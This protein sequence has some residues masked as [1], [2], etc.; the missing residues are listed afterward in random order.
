MTGTIIASQNP[1]AISNALGT[2]NFRVENT[3]DENVD[4]EYFK[5][6]F[7][8]LSELIEAG[9]DLVEEVEGEGAVL[10]KNDNN[11]LP[12]A[13]GSKI[14]LFSVSSVKPAYGGRGSA[15][16]SFPQPP[17][18]PKEGFENAGFS[19]NES[20]NNFYLTNQGKYV[21]EGRGDQALV[22]D[23]PWTDIVA[24]NLDTSIREYSDAAFFIV[25]RVGGEGSDLASKGVA[26]GTDGDHLKLSVNE[27]SVLKGLKELK[28]AGT[29]KKIIVLLNTSNQIQSSYL[30]DPELGV[31]AA[32]WIGSVGVTGF[33]AVGKL[34]SGDITPSGHL[35]DAHWYNH[36]DNPVSKNFGAYTYAGVNDY[37]LPIVAGKLILSI[38]HTMYIKKVYILDIDML[39]QD[40]QTLLQIEQMLEHLLIRMLFH[41][42]LVMVHHIQNLNSLISKQQN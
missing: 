11:A 38:L 31:D 15:Q 1:T 9:R 34:V 32:L 2:P 6:K 18:T 42:H 26:D 33:N 24:A 40:M 5:S 39:K 16:T 35:S 36:K 4:S 41:I 17:V 14:S 13:K 29:I 10:L 7:S 25:T 3:G 30:V 19:V 23:A 20:L 12:L 27:R 37:S 21:S 22:K 28:D 8:S